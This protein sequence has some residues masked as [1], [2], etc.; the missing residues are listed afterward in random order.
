M[1]ND[2][3]ETLNLFYDIANGGEGELSGI[4]IADFE[5]NIAPGFPYGGQYLGM[6][7]VNEFFAN[8]KKHFDFWTVSTE[9]FISISKNSMAV[10]GTYFAKAKETG[11]EFE[12]ETV[13][14]WKSDKDKLT[15]LKQ[16]CDT[17]ILSNAMANKVPT[18][19]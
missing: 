6:D 19:I 18:R 5:L 16:Y 11:I 2:L 15:S 8:Y 10:T 3:E 12:M 9:K 4:F 13:H 7:G 14:F 1:S 17:A